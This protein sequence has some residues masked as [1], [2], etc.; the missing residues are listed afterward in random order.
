MSAQNVMVERSAVLSECAEGVVDAKHDRASCVVCDVYRYELRRVWGPGPLCVW[1][2]LNPSTADGK[3]DDATIRKCIRLA[4]RWGSGGI[5]VVNLYGLRATDPR[6]LWR[7]PD[8]VGP[9]NDR[10][11]WGVL[12][13]PGALVVC[14]WG[15]HGRRGNDVLVELVARG[16]QPQCLALTSAG[17]PRHPLYLT[18]SLRP[19]PLTVR[20]TTTGG[21]R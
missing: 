12:G 13:M 9:E 15:A 18:E 3:Q 21:S 2:M 8:P 19:M 17:Q 7:H 1:V 16:V 20:A 11:V 10:H 4:K 6:E 5:V 14:A